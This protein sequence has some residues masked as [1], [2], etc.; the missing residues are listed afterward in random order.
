MTNITYTNS[1]SKRIAFVNG[2]L[3]DC[4]KMTSDITNII[5]AGGKVMGLGYLPDD[6]EGTEFYDIGNCLIV[7][8]LCDAYL[9]SFAQVDDAQLVASGI[10]AIGNGDGSVGE[11]A[12]VR[13]LPL[14]QSV[15]DLRS[16][17]FSDNDVVFPLT[18][19]FLLGAGDIKR[20][21]VG[22]SPL[23]ELLLRKG[24]ELN[25]ILSA[26]KSELIDAI[27][28]GND[29]FILKSGRS[30]FVPI[31]MSVLYRDNQLNWPSVFKLASR[32]AAPLFEAKMSSMGVLSV[33]SFS[34]IDPNFECDVT[35]DEVEGLDS[36]IGRALVGR[37]WMGRC[38]ATVVEGR[39]LYNLVKPQEPDA[40]SNSSKI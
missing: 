27:V 20:W 37:K 31:L 10:T 18:S 39:L 22:L 32:G 29:S 6:D 40:A 7:P 17:V 14:K 38:L 12:M 36:D 16:D 3:I 21:R 28:S 19:E 23:S 9:T 15:C 5:I 1:N 33:P 13:C 25:A 34:V 24:S 26:I 8:H 35:E 4:Q 11:S 30:M 2:K